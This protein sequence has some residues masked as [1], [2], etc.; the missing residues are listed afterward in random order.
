MTLPRALSYISIQFLVFTTSHRSSRMG[1]HFRPVFHFF[2]I[3]ESSMKSIIHGKIIMTKERLGF[4]SADNKARVLF[5]WY[6]LISSSV[7][8]GVNFREIT[9][10]HCKVLVKPHV[11]S[12]T[13]QGKK[14]P[15]KRFMK[16]CHFSGRC[17]FEDSTDEGNGVNISSE[18]NYKLVLWEQTHI[19]YMRIKRQ[20]TLMSSF[21]FLLTMQRRT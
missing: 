12:S 15:F 2:I 19:S 6:S 7:I 8:S 20:F 16:R 21:Y 14:L 11:L 4:R 17:L 13:G 1:L 9:S 18:T 3:L 10:M 5:W